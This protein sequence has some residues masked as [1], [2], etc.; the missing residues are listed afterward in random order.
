MNTTKEG[1]QY[2]NMKVNL[3]KALLRYLQIEEERMPEINN[4]GEGKITI[5]IE[6]MGK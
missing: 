6:A 4:D 3:R 5:Q 2:K 1:G